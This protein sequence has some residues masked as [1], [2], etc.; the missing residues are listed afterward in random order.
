MV[1]ESEHDQESH[2]TA[3][4]GKHIQWQERDGV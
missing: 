4:D 2:H 1:S 3:Q